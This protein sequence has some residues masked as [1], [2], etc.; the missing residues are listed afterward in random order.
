M[1]TRYALWLLAPDL[2]TWQSKYLVGSTKVDTRD[3]NALI[4]AAREVSSTYAPVRGVFCYDE[5][6]ILPAA[7]AAEALGLPGHPAAAI[8]ACRDKHAGRVLMAKAGVDQPVSI[9]VASLEEARKAAAQVGYP[10][11]IKPRALSA[12]IGVSLVRDP[13]ELDAAYRKSR[14]AFVSELPPC[15]QPNVL[16]EEFVTGTPISVD[17]A[18]HNGVVTPLV[19]AHNETG[20]PPYF[21]ELAHIVRADDPLLTDP[22]VLETLQDSHAALGLT[23]GIT[24]TELRVSERGALVIEVNAR[25]GGD[26][27]PYGGLLARQV[28]VGLIAADLAVGVEPDLSA[29][30]QNTA[31]IRFLYPPYDM[32]VTSIKVDRSQ[33]PDGVTMLETM[34]SPGQKLLLPPNDN[35]NCRTAVVVAVGEDEANALERLCR[36]SA[37]VVVEGVPLG[38]DRPE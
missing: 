36:A 10:L 4:E 31:A 21:E 26:L 15:P 28:D 9:A 35:V 12:S 20:Y 13:A 27:I 22:R 25:I 38:S 34:V 18:C 24:H 30:G 3:S 2:P 37:A 8:E 19:L 7:V 32:E 23:E 29:Q 11:V 14:S 16:V 1:S 6:R 5:S 33:V 17:A